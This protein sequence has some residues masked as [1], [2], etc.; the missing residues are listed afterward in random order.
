MCIRDSPGRAQP[1]NVSSGGCAG[2]SPRLCDERPVLCLLYTS[3]SSDTS[4]E[5][6]EVVANLEARLMEMEIGPDRKSVV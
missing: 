6:G 4:L 2:G 3:N 5:L 1:E